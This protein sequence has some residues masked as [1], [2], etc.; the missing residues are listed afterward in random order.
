ML[1]LLFHRRKM[2]HYLQQIIRA[3]LNS[4]QGLHVRKWAR[5]RSGVAEGTEKPAEIWAVVWGNNNKIWDT[6][7]LNY[8]NNFL[9]RA[10]YIFQS[11]KVQENKKVIIRRNR[12]PRN[13]VVPRRK[14][15]SRGK[16]QQSSSTAL[17]LGQGLLCSTERTEGSGGRSWRSE[18]WGNLIVAVWCLSGQI[19][20]S[21][22]QMQTVIF[23]RHSQ[24]SLWLCLSCF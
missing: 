10:F 1:G 16:S 13:F 5:S 23:P 3:F 20:D 11:W 22:S 9:L 8:I 7:A 2:V 12:N 4:E 21:R 18:G 6:S 14:R 24:L 19:K 15:S 17:S